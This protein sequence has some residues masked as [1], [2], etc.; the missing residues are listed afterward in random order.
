MISNNPF[1]QSTENSEENSR[2]FSFDEIDEL[3]NS[4][5]PVSMKGNTNNK[6]LDANGNLRILSKKEILILMDAMEPDAKS[7]DSVTDPEALTKEKII[8]IRNG[9]KN[10]CDDDLFSQDEISALLNGEII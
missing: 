4:I 8:N 5:K 9:L 7:Q 3:L 1:D 10:K 2:G 6:N